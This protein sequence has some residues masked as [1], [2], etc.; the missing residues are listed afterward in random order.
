MGRHA[1]YDDLLNFGVLEPEDVLA[2]HHYTAVRSNG[3]AMRSMPLWCYTSEK[4]FQA[5]KAKIF[6][7]QWNLLEREEIVPNVGDY[8]TMAFLGVPLIVA[9][10]RDEKVRVFA[11][12]CRHRGAL[13]AEGKGNCKVFRCPYHFWTYGLDGRLI[14]APN[15][16]DSTGKSLIDS[17]NKEEFGLVEID[18]GTWG[19]FIFI[20]FKEGPETLQQH[21]GTLVDVL[22]SHSLQDMRCARKVVYD[23]DAN[24]KC[25]VENYIDAYHI[26]YVH[27][28]SLAQW[29]TTEYVRIKPKGRETLALAKH[30]GSQLLLPSADYV[31]FPAMP[32]IDEDKA[33]GTWFATLRPGM[34]MTLGN[35]GALV[36]QSEP[37]S[38]KKSKLT[39]SSLFPKSYFEREDF[40][41]I[42]Q[43]YY[44]RND[45]VVVEDKEI[46]LRQ[47]AGIQ[48]PYARIPRLCSEETSLN[49]FGNWVLDQVLPSDDRTTIAAE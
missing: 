6:L 11:N 45:I 35:D 28:D 13:L 33:R 46:A 26:P 21:L 7:P 8:H 25:F 29:K 10:G 17:D 43:N 9:R 5:E 39:I 32:Q 41:R 18:S 44:R 48:S 31:G 24:W 40:E 15:Y 42:S 36:F 47:F 22:A 30:E 19:G 38:A 23:M 49:T 12:T 34:L 14:G 4:F 3:R 1:A 20:R 16:T 2:P 37:V 27:R